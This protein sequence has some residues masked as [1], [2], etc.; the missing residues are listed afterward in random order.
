MK[1]C[2]YFQS[3]DSSSMSNTNS[4][5]LASFLPEKCLTPAAAKLLDKCLLESE[6]SNGYEA[7]AADL[8]HGCSRTFS[9]HRTSV[10]SCNANVERATAMTH[11]WLERDEAGHI[12]SSKENTKQQCK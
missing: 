2:P 5:G 4:R 10:N 12:V 9:E 11:V 8:S 7:T 6:Q 1:I 3:N